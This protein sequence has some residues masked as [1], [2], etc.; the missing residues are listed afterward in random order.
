LPIPKGVELFGA[1]PWRKTEIPFDSFMR[2]AVFF[3]I[4]GIESEAIFVSANTVV[5]IIGALA[6]YM[7]LPRFAF[8]AVFLYNIKNK[9]ECMA[10]FKG[11]SRRGHILGTDRLGCNFGVKFRDNLRE[12]VENAA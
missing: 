5:L 2:R 4:A 11:A 1:F 7:S 12:A 3:N 10:L 6:K 8:A 9:L